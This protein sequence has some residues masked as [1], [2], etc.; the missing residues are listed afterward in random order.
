MRT[1]Y[2]SFAAG[3]LAACVLAA[4]V[5]PATA[6]KTGEN[7]DAYH[8]NG[9]VTTAAT[10]QSAAHSMLRWTATLKDPMDW[11]SSVSDPL[12]IGDRL[13]IAVGQ[14]LHV[15]RTTDGKKSG[16]MQLAAPVDYTCRPAYAQ[17]KLYFPL[18]GGRLQVVQADSLK[19]LWV[20]DSLDVANQAPHQTQS[21]LTVYDGKVYF[22]TGCLDDNYEAASGAF[23]CFDATR[24]S[25]APL[26]KYDAKGVGCYWSGPAF[27]NGAVIFGN[28]SGKLIALNAGTGALLA[29]KTLPAG[30]RSTA[31]AQGDA[32]LLTT[33]NGALHHVQV[34]ADGTL[35]VDKSVQFAD[36]STCT[37]TIAAGKVYVG[38]QK[39]AYPDVSGVLAEVDLASLRVLH[40]AKLPAD[41][42]S[43]PLVSVASGQPVVYCTSNN[44]PGALYVYRNGNAS[45]L[46]TP[47][48][49][50][51]NYCMASPVAGP[52]G[53]VYY[54]NDSGKLFA[55]AAVPEDKP[56]SSAPSSTP[57]AV[58]PV[59]S[60]NDPSSTGSASAASAP[61]AASAVSSAVSGGASGS[62][63]SSGPST[64]AVLPTTEEGDSPDTGDSG[65][66]LPA[67]VA[68]T[69]AAMALL[70]YGRRRK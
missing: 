66:A 28:D 16:E 53:T 30:I 8:A 19:S 52:D 25:A 39:G 44:T 56:V 57:N 49:D 36:S 13:Y 42:K 41:V 63:S 55:L 12:V 20:T 29:E 7:W 70:L 51:Q 38:G 21:T 43:A 26:W 4:S 18:P 22:G 64:V 3:L 27:I 2:K 50:A 65:A 48:Q 17:G 32:V 40:S 35:G 37:P 58:Q 24:A 59:E 69:G 6:A 33:R 67:A 31:V 68:V 54:T 15:Y 1:S 14:K 9:G 61:Q 45:A 11:S 5:P 10:P 60:G 62:S 47:A 46:Y 23:L 34:R